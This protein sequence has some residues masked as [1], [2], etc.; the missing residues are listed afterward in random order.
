MKLFARNPSSSNLFQL[1]Y[2]DFDLSRPKQIDKLEPSTLDVDLARSV[3]V[4]QFSE[5]IA[6][7]GDVVLFRGYVEKDE[8]NNNKMKSISCIGME[9]LLNQRF[10]NPYFYQRDVTTLETIFSHSH[11]NGQVPGL[12]AIANSGFP[13]G[14]DYSYYNED[15]HVVK[16]KD[17]GKAHRFGLR[18]VF[19]LDL[20]FLRELSEL[21]SITQTTPIDNSFYRDQEDMYIKLKD[22]EH[23][24]W[25]DL[26]GILVEEA[27]DTTTRMGNIATKYITAN[28]QTNW[29][30]I[31]DLLINIAIG[32]GLFPHFRPGWNYTYID[33]D[34]IEGR[35]TGF[36]FDETDLSSIER[37]C[38]SD[39][40]L[41]AVIGQGVGNQFYS[42]GDLTYKGIWT[43]EKH[44]VDNGFKDEDGILIP[45]T[46]AFYEGRLLDHQWVISFPRKLKKYIF[47]PGD[48]I[49]LRPYKDAEERLS[50]TMI[51]ESANGVITFELGAKRPTYATAWDILNDTKAGYTD[52]YLRENASSI[53]QTGTVYPS[54]RLHLDAPACELTF[55]VPEKVLDTDLKPRITLE[56]SLTPDGED[57]PLFGRVA[58]LIAVDDIK[59]NV[60]Q[61]VATAMGDV[62]DEGLPEIDITDLVTADADNVI[63][64]WVKMAAE[65]SDS[66]TAYDEHPLI[67]VSATMKFYKR[68]VIE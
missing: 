65:W 2:K 11:T 23:R 17:A 15:E 20:E 40:M 58:I 8:I 59:P 4:T 19:G 44:E 39:P 50:C 43:Q 42:T 7:E 55:A 27:F 41:H 30:E 47:W 26:G 66:H 57:K 24:G 21:T 33:V 37:K 32:H 56:L 38:P 6:A 1:K 48:Y 16:I 68:E 3:P 61:L 67:N 18:R 60:G 52:R 51:T 22:H 12:L 13:P 62:A 46:D 34:D 29:D 10:A 5:V 53:S 35:E 49:T 28:L 54:D 14:W 25:P 64:V 9:A 36:I 45:H 63:K 31:G